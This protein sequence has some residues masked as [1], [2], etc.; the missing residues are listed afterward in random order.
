LQTLYPKRSEERLCNDLKTDSRFKAK[1]ADIRDAETIR[2]NLAYARD[3]KHN[4]IFQGIADSYA[5]RAMGKAGKLT[6]AEESEI[7]QRA[8]DEALNSI[9]TTWRRR[10]TNND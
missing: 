5:H 2:R 6:P 1:Y 8:L 7:R 9:S 4:E 3:P 10:A